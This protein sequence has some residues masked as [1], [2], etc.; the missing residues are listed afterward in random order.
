MSGRFDQRLNKLV[1]RLARINGEILDLLNSPAR[2]PTSV[3][4]ACRR[5]L[6]IADENEWVMNEEN[7][8]AC[9]TALL[10]AA[11]TQAL[12]IQ[13]LDAQRVGFTLAVAAGRTWSVPSDDLSQRTPERWG[14]WVTPAYRFATIDAVGVARLLDEPDRDASWDV[15]GRVIWRPTAEM[16]LSAEALYRRVGTSETAEAGG[17]HSASHSNRTSGMVEYRLRDDLSL[18]GTFGQDFRKENGER[19]L[20]TLFGLSLG[21]G[22]TPSVQQPSAPD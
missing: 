12:A 2:D 14:V 20:I 8:D 11:T 3:V 13:A 22:N 4:Q 18:Y 19:P 5:T 9:R 1:T 7:L 21:L 15:G 16:K 10:D 6:E 17:S